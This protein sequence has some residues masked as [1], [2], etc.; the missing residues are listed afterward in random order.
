M[1]LNAAG[2]VGIGTAN[3]SYKLD[4]SINTVN[5]GNVRSTGGI[6]GFYLQD[7]DSNGNGWQWYSQDGILKLYDNTATVGDRF[8][9]KKNGTN[10][11]FGING[12][13]STN[14]ILT[15]NNVSSDDRPAIKIV[16]PNF[17]SDTSSTGRTFYRWMPI[18]ID[19]TTY[20]IPIYTA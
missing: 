20:W 16:N 9:V 18:D 4:T 8:F 15:I 12:S 11:E 17:Y 3:P 10:A 5:F 13:P 1:V 7:R 14:R 6:A 2:N 19:S